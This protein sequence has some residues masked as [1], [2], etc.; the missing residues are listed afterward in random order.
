LNH[1]N[2]ASIYGLEDSGAAHALVMEL[3][4]QKR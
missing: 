3:T 1:P 2:I 4:I